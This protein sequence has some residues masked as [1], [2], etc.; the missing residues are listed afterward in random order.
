MSVP[1]TY[2]TFHK[3]L[4]KRKPSEEPSSVGRCFSSLPIRTRPNSYNYNTPEVI[5]PPYFEFDK[6]YHAF[7][8]CRFMTLFHVYGNDGVD[9]GI[10]ITTPCVIYV[11]R[12]CKY[13]KAN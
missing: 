6:P 5:N 7:I 2:S 9:L 11:G 8:E 12:T 13:M 4:A 3:G 10:L 1:L